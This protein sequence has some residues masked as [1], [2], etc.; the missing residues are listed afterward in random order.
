MSRCLV[1]LGRA[2]RDLA[3]SLCCTA[4]RLAAPSPHLS[5]P[6][7]SADSIA[8]LCSARRA[9]TPRIAPAPSPQAIGANQQSIQHAGP[10]V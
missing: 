2:A 1:L 4:R 8:A 9:R 6:L 5:L 3:S 10:D 7:W